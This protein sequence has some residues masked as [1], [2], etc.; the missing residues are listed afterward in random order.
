M[1]P[2][3]LYDALNCA[4][5]AVLQAEDGNGRK[6]EEAY[7]EASVAA[8]GAFPEGSPEALALNVLLGAVGDLARGLAA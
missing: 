4:S 2:M 3:A 5:L 6:A 8:M 7:M 1:S